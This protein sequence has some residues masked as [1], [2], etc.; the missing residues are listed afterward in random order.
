MAAVA[1]EV[2]TIILVARSEPRMGTPLVARPVR[3]N[4][5][6]VPKTGTPAVTPTAKRSAMG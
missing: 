6:P 3:V 5:V 2:V 4:A 1:V